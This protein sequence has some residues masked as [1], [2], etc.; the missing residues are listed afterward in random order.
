M[1]PRPGRSEWIVPTRLG[2]DARPVRGVEAAGESEAGKKC[3]TKGDFSRRG[4]TCQHGW[5][6]A[7]RG[8]RRGAQGPASLVLGRPAPCGSRTA[9]L[10]PRF[11]RAASG[12]LS[13][14]VRVPSWPASPGPRAKGRAAGAGSGEPPSGRV[15][16]LLRHFVDVLGGP[17]AE[18]G[19]GPRRSRAWGGRGR[20]GKGS[21]RSSRR[22]DTCG[23]EG[24]GQL[25]TAVSSPLAASRASEGHASPSHP[26][27][28]PGPALHACSHVL[29]PPGTPGPARWP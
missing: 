9:F 7:P 16:K 12:S 6:P 5:W 27:A 8:E 23:Q 26:R 21:S 29:T 28:G 17:C 2:P 13:L 20:K 18:K 24:G 3:S 11:L 1:R 25:G 19:A 4:S 10:G 15:Q 14:A 22:K